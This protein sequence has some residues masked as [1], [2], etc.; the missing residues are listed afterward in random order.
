M[1]Q[2][3]NNQSR[4]ISEYKLLIMQYGQG[5][6]CLPAYSSLKQDVLKLRVHMLILF[7]KE[8]SRPKAALLFWF[9]GDFRCGALLFMVSHVI[10][11]YKSR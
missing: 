4:C 8:S 2:H 1:R 11:K 7:A 10:Y 3:L 6:Y 5:L 9:F